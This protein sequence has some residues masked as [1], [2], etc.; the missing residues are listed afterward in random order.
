MC[1]AW[2][3]RP[4]W[5]AACAFS[6]CKS[7]SFGPATSLWIEDGRIRRIGDDAE[8]N[9]ASGTVTL[10]GVGRFVIPGLFDLHVHATGANQ[11]AFLAYGVTS[12]RDTGGPIAYLNAIQDRGELTDLPVPRYFWAGEIFEGD[13]PYHGDTFL[14]IDTESDARAYVERLKARWA[15]FIKVYPSLSW[16]LKRAVAEEAHRLGLPVVGHG[17]SPEEIVKSVTLGFFSLEHTSELNRD[18]AF[19]DELRMLAAAGTRWDPTVVVLGGDAL[20]LRDEPERLADTKFLAFTPSWYVDVARSSG[21][22]NA[23]ATGD[24]RGDVA[25]QLASIARGHALGVKL[26]VGTDA[27][28]TEVFYG[29]S[30]HW[31]LS[32]FVEGGLTPLEVI[33]LA[34]SGV[35]EAVGATDLGAVQEGKLA[36]LLL[37]DANPLENIRNTEKIWRVV[38]GGRVF[39]PRH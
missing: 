38:K 35:A 29:S 28:N 30:L 15:S 8:R 3:P 6:T 23:R 9:L 36:D 18:R 16:P 7:G 13:R 24:L 39:D 27:P 26:L 25:G 17:T 31:E 1:P 33:R 19:D 37:L 2:R 14:Q 5:F 32:R 21:Y 12:L 4:L 20:L 22:F 34:T 10:D 11:E